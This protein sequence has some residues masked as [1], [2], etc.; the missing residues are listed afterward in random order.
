M[1]GFVMDGMIFFGS[2]FLFQICQN[3]K[4]VFEYLIICDI[5]QGGGCVTYM[6]TSGHTRSHAINR[7]NERNSGVSNYDRW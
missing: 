6:A 7:S 3:S 1:I 5:S 2:S 4:V